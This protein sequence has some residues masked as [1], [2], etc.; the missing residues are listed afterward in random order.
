MGAWQCPEC[1]ETNNGEI[2]ICVCGYL[3]DAGVHKKE[4]IPSSKNEK[5]CSPRIIQKKVRKK[6]KSIFQLIASL[7]SKDRTS[8]SENWIQIS[9][10]RNGYARWTLLLFF[11]IFYF[12]GTTDGLW[13]IAYAAVAIASRLEC[14]EKYGASFIYG[15]KKGQTIREYGIGRSLTGILWPA[16]LREDSLE[17]LSTITGLTLLVMY[18]LHLYFG[19]VF[20]LDFLDEEKTA[21]ILTILNHPFADLLSY[22]LSYQET[23][24][25][26]IAHG[27]ANRIPLLCHVYM[28]TAIS[29]F[30]YLFCSLL[31]IIKRD[32]S[33]K[34]WYVF[35]R[36]QL[37]SFKSPG[38]NTFF[39]RFFDS[40]FRWPVGRWIITLV[41]CCGLMLFLYAAARLPLYFPGEPHP[42]HGKYI[43][44]YSFAYRDN[45]G[46]FSPILIMPMITLC[47]GGILALFEPFYWSG[48]YLIRFCRKLI[49][50]LMRNK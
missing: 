8:L 45:I 10:W 22:W 25:K 34:E 6:K 46:L 21:K 39:D 28:V 41:I 20:F 19:I 35:K 15:K 40:L 31:Y 48:L 26:F 3:D 12:R 11:A 23:A 30:A 9:T 17:L 27:Y 16:A 29:S 32:S 7:H 38:C 24:E 13:L 1:G 37:K 43:W 50:I 36:E 49:T 18:G 14:H 47:I 33:L 44:M 2:L 42:R 4:S 5:L